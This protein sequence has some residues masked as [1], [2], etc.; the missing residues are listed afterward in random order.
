MPDEDKTFSDSLVLDLRIWRR[1]AHIL[2]SLNPPFQLFWLR[3]VSE[4]A[5]I[6]SKISGE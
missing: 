1:H 2:Y 3:F 6:V 4:A 5:R